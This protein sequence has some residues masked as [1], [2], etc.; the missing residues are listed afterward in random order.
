LAQWVGKGRIWQK[1]QTTK[2]TAAAGDHDGVDP[3][4]REFWSHRM[5]NTVERGC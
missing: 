1:K 5:T 3:N 2:I 4:G